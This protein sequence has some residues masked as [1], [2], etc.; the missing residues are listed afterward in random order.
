VAND[1]DPQRVR[2]AQIRWHAEPWQAH[3]VMVVADALDIY[4]LPRVGAAWMPTGS[5]EA[6]MTP[7]KHAKHCVAG[8]LNLVTGE[9]IDGLG[10]RQTHAL[11]RDLLTQLDLA[12]PAPRVTRISVVVD[13]DA[14]HKAKAVEQWLASHPRL[15]V[16]RWPTSGPRAN[17]SEWVFGEVHDQC[18]RNHQRKR[19]CDVVRDVERH[20][21]QNNPWLHKL[22]RVYDAPEV[23]AAVEQLAAE[24]QAKRAA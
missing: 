17:P 7:G 21:R 24:Q 19:L 22:S 1:D 5:Q 15:I 2:L 12:Y 10:P 4:L 13:H 14:I 3:E 23:T 6:V 20:L 18:T 8:A 9:I 16:R 11:F